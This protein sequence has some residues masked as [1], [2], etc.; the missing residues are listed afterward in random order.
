MQNKW[1]TPNKNIKFNWYLYGG[2]VP[3]EILDKNN[4]IDIDLFKTSKEEVLRL[5]NL[6]LHVV[7]YFSA[8]SHEPDRPDGEL[9]KN[10]GLG[11]VL[12]GWEQKKWVDI[13]LQ[14]V[15]YVMKKRIELAY[16]KGFD[17]IEPDNVNMYEYDSYDKD[18]NEG[19]HP[20]QDLK[21]QKWSKLNTTNGCQK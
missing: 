11:N 21:Y 1:W 6:G 18:I 17:A 19:A 5:K 10:T 9:L 3:N 7:A 20:L 14:K 4:V 8:G 2:N 12:E 13:R 16:L 15:K